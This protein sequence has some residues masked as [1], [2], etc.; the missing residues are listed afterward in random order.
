MNWEA[1]S[2][3]STAFTGL[4]ILATAI[5]AIREVRIAADHSRAT[6]DQ[7]EHLRKST[8]F[9]GALA[10]FGELDTPFQQHARRFVQFQLAERMNDPQFRAEVALLAGADELEHKELTVLRCFERIGTYVRKGLVDP[11][12]VYCAAAGRVIATWR[13]LDDVVAIH[14]AIAGP[15][16]WENYERLYH[17]SKTWQHRRGL[18]VANLERQQTHSDVRAPAYH[19]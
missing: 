9:E 1:F 15:A 6:R 13:A 16:F 18:N 4:V 5:A 11:D 10:V 2:A 17:A 19:A 8:Q 3:V 14:R 12:V 7:L